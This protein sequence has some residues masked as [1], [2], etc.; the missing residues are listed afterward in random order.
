MAPSD[1]EGTAAAADPAP[2]PP[3]AADGTVLLNR[4]YE[5]DVRQPLGLL[6]T[7]T[8]RAYGARDRRDERG[9]VFAYVC[10]SPLPPRTDIL[11]SMKGVETPALMKMRDFGVV[12]WP[13]NGVQY[14]VI[15]YD[16]TRGK[17]L[18]NRLDDRIDP[19][20]EDQLMRLVIQPVANALRELKGHRV[21]AG[22]INP[23][24]AFVRSSPGQPVLL[25]DFATAP[26]GLNQPLVFE[27]IE[28]GMA[29]PVGRGTGTFGDDLYAFGVFLLFLALGRNPAQGM[30]D[31]EIL[32][33][34]LER[35]SYAALVRDNRLTGLMTEPIRGL[36][37]DDP[38]QRWTIEDLDLWLSG[39][40]LSPKQPQP[41]KRAQRPLVFGGEDFFT[42]RALAFAMHK[43]PLESLTLIDS[44]E[45]DMWLR[46]SMEDDTLADQVQ[47]GVR[48]ASTGSG[49]SPSD[50]RLA[51]VLM[52]LDPPAPIRYRSCSVMPE[53]IGVSMIQSLAQTGQVQELGELVSAQLPI[54]WIN[55]QRTFSPEYVAVMKTFETARGYI[56]RIMPGFGIERCL[57]HL[58]PG[59]PCRSPILERYYVQELDRLLFA[60]DEIADAPS[61]PHQPYDRHIL[62]FILS[63][64][65]GISERSLTGLTSVSSECDQVLSVLDILFE[66]QRKSRAFPLPRLGAW[67]V[68][69]M[70]PAIERYN[71]RSL[72]ERVL[73]ELQKQ[74][75][76]GALKNLYMILQNRNLLARDGK[77]F[78]IAKREY[79]LA[80]QVVLRRQREN[81]NRDD[82]VNGIGRQAAAVVASLL[83]ALVLAGIVVSGVG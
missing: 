2:P 68:D 55:V 67:L 51:R 77:A 41:A 9:E 17:A 75:E 57:Y 44:G 76:T 34:K 46:R 33:A 69:L 79:R 28:R 83:S 38:A 59:M 27:T 12:T 42:T 23:T 26:P 24:N 56:D 66:V 81:E 61:R 6:D 4:R 8:A 48:T 64:H 15:L 18:M 52:A 37:L 43:K 39:R 65:G 16:R 7:P 36:L 35:G 70:G 31:D 60:L 63:R 14:P 29:T 40:R 62:A 47:E 54:F 22:Q 20:T 73:G 80:G 3:P 1:A 10:T 30:S 11:G 72:R 53:G 45:L 25:G 78:D 58:N 82:F 32:Q 74:A 19:Y 5:I 71:S 49:G 13:E 50:R 21:F